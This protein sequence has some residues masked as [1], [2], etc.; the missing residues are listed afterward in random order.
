MRVQRTRGTV[1]S[2]SWRCRL[3]LQTP[4]TP[5]PL[6]KHLHQTTRLNQ[7]PRLAKRNYYSLVMP[8]III[9]K[10]SSPPILQP[11]LANLIT[12]NMKIP[13]RLPNTLEILPLIDIYPSL[14]SLLPLFHT[15]TRSLSGPSNSISCPF[16]YSSLAFVSRYSLLPSIN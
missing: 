6:I 7:P 5:H 3:R 9:R 15:V 1:S 14:V 4:P 13:N 16:L 8:Y 11:L 12:P 2:Q 10:F